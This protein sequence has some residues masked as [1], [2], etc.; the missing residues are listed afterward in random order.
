MRTISK[1]AQLA[2]CLSV[3][4]LCGCFSVNGQGYSWDDMKKG[5][6][7]MTSSA[8]EKE[9]RDYIARNPGDPLAELLRSDPKMILGTAHRGLYFEESLAALKERDELVEA[10]FKEPLG[11][12]KRLNLIQQIGAKSDQVIAT[13]R[14]G[15]ERKNSE[16]SLAK[17]SAEQQA[18]ALSNP[19]LAQGDINM[20]ERQLAFIKQR[21]ADLAAVP[22]AYADPFF[23]VPLPPKPGEAPQEKK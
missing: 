17:A 14:L 20:L 7:S 11:S 1:L 4:M 22:A 19:A 13:E 16:V 18:K 12:P 9:N 8:T 15:W 6:Q 5:F 3:L 23:S 21:Q 2:L 10:S